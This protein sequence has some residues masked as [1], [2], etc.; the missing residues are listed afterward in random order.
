MKYMIG[1]CVALLS[2]SLYAASITN[3]EKVGNV[4]GS[5]QLVFKNAGVL[6]R[7][8]NTAEPSA[9]IIL[10]FPNTTS[11]IPGKEVP[12][13]TSGIYDVDIHQ[14]GGRTRA[15]INLAFP[16]TYDVSMRGKDVVVSIN[17]SQVTAAP[18]PQIKP[19]VQPITPVAKGLSPA[20]RK[21]QG[22]KKGVLVFQLPSEKTVVNVSNQGNNIVADIGGI[23]LSAGEQKR[24]DVTDYS[25]PV[26]YV[27]IKRS[28]SGARISL[29]MGKND[30]E[31]IT[32]Q[33]GLTY[34]IEVDEPQAKDSVKE[35]MSVI[36][37]LTEYKEYR[38]EPLSL[39]FQDIEVRAVLQI[40]AE[41]TGNN[42]AVSDEVTG[43]IT[44]RLDNVPWDQAL[45]IILKTKRLGKRVN[46]GVIYVGLAD[47]LDNDEIV[48][49]EAIRKKSENTPPKS[50]TIQLRY[51]KAKDMMDL[52]EKSRSVNGA[53]G[54]N[55]A[56]DGI[57]SPKGRV[58]I[59]ERTNTLVISD[60][61]IKLQAVRE[62]INKLD[63][64]VRQVLVDARIVLTTDN[65][66]HE[67]G[68]GFRGGN[69]HNNGRM[70]SSGFSDNAS[71]Y[72]NNTD[73]ARTNPAALVG[74]GA[75]V[76]TV[77]GNVNRRLGVNL[78]AV[79]SV[80][81]LGLSILSG[82]FLIGLEL[83]AL[84]TE[85]KI[86][87]V[88]SPRVVTQ[89]GINATIM[90]GQALPRKAATA[91]SVSI[92][93]VDAVLSL[94]VTPRIT[95]DSMINLDLKIT[96]DDK[97]DTVFLDGEEFFSIN[98]NQLKTS[99][100]VDNGETLVLGGFYKQ[101]QTAGISKT[102]ILSSIPIIG[103]A[104][105][106]N[107]KSFRKDELLIFVTP[108]IVDKRLVEYDKFSNLRN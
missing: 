49:L 105:K 11:G 62:L 6:P 46:N 51:A 5:Y 18:A 82:D 78:G 27:D 13:A 17:T 107:T 85:G 19:A 94:D 83:A 34:T 80:A 16:M 59:D 42:I 26:N 33:S 7:S 77:T 14:G 69:A 93:Y 84:Q 92:D 74:A 23:K 63:E 43:N 104:F 88:S 36:D 55:E 12:V 53:N 47:R 48:A 24:L 20:F 39:N 98:K 70:T 81:Q 3:I 32:Y 61:P 102:P 44:L 10:D 30:Y 100:L 35:Q 37:G 72:T 87:V 101:T 95:P 96:N 66:N 106:K 28:G 29:N 65:F 57:L 25:T 15:V 67:F 60:I 76:P 50:E 45:D 64:P 54:L 41:F 91:D 103:E 58:T 68:V 31:F 89:D 38:G 108:R 22:N 4:A 75:V 79:D 71:G 86:E 1:T 56:N 97:G 40:I 73:Y 21:G 99:A 52:I 9:A 8:F 2:S 90:S